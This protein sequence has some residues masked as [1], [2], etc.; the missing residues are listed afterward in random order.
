[1]KTLLDQLSAL[2]P[3]PPAP[4]NMIVVKAGDN[5]QT[6]VNTAA[7]G[8]TI[9]ITPGTTFQSIVLPNKSTTVPITIRPCVD[10][11]LLPVP[12]PRSTPT[13]F[14]PATM[15][16]IAPTPG[17][18]YG[19][20]VNKG[21]GPYTIIGLHMTS[22]GTSGTMIAI[23]DDPFVT[24]A[25][26]PHNITIDRCILDGGNAAKRGISE[27]GANDSII[28]SDIF[29][30]MKQ[31]QDTQAI[32]GSRGPGPYLIQN[33]YL[34]AGGETLIFGG[35]DPKIS[36]LI[37]SNISILH[38]YITKDLA[39]KTISATV[40]N[41][42][43]LKNARHVDFEFNTVE[44]TWVDEQ[45]GWLLVLT[46]RDQNG[47]APWSTL[48]DITIKSN[49]FRHGNQGVQ[50]LGLDDQKDTTTGLVHP[51]VRMSGVTIANNLWYDV[52]TTIWGGNG[53]TRAIIVNNGPVGVTYS[54][55]T[56]VGTT[57]GFLALTLGISKTISTG[58]NLTCNV[59]PEGNWGISGDGSVSMGAPSWTIGVD[60]TSVFDW[61]AI[62]TTGTTN[63]WK[64]P[65]LNTRYAPMTFSASFVASPPLT[66]SDGT[67]VGVNLQSL[68]AGIPGLD[69]T[70]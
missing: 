31:G 36:G 58:L 50:I 32:G 68:I 13:A 33:N 40:K 39:W 63:K 28:N 17:I 42:V 12:G 51:S 45:T 55:N 65:G 49:V 57:G 64:Y 67:P 47:T 54:H 25:D 41:V 43:E 60:P 8:T 70:K 59:F 21:A 66:C 23:G 4:T 11:S 27:E 14:N 26:V 3:V 6:I 15:F 44:H 34:S 56:V 22:P 62:Y 7:P 30:I 1:M 53:A 2:L 18:N 16:T 37:P 48:N 61:N 69:L 29:G 38:N 10:D 46:V 24:L 19:I 9:C 5:L 52:G 35:D 20:W